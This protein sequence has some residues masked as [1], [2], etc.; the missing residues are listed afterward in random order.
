MT[1]PTMDELRA[2]V[3]KDPRYA[4]TPGKGPSGEVCRGCDHLTST[5]NVKRHYKCGLTAYTSGDAT[6]IKVM[7][8]ACEHFEP[9]ILRINRPK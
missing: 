6:T 9:F 1:R 8:P 2:R 3:P 4:G 5:G 7:T